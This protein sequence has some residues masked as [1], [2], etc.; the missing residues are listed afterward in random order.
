MS[1][2]SHDTGE[3]NVIFV[4]SSVDDYPLTPFEF[5]VYGKIARRA[6]QGEGWPSIEQV[7]KECLMSEDTARQ[8]LQN[9][10]TFGMLTRREVPGKR[11]RYRLTRPSTWAT[12]EVVAA[13]HA[14]QADKGRT[15]RQERKAKKEQAQNEPAP[16]TETAKSGPST[17]P[18]I[19]HP[20]EKQGGVES[21]TPGKNREG[22]PS[23]KHPPHPSEKQG[24]VSIS[25]EVDPVEV[26]PETEIGRE[27]LPQ[28]AVSAEGQDQDTGTGAAD[29]AGANTPTSP[30]VQE[31]LN[32][33]ANGRAPNATS[34]KD[35]PGAARPV[36][37]PVD[38]FPEGPSRKFLTGCF[39][40]E[41]L[42]R[43]LEEDPSR[44]DWF[45]LEAETFQ[46][47]KDDAVTTSERGKWKGTLIGLLDAETAKA[48]RA[49]RPRAPGAA[50]ATSITDQINARIA[51]TRRPE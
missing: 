32:P 18:N 51:A 36:E 38:N 15:K 6:G 13:L 44:A 40:G 22:Y 9:L 19:S 12:R 39:G 42:G 35:G 46:V 1:E 50:P 11:A 7:A 10:V 47:S 25:T 30:P 49:R 23:E 34:P 17:P 4:H 41:W 2:V 3:M 26:D 14:E 45:G 37:N 28:S 31:P 33:K 27:A 16:E 21:P 20:S 43:L 8:A 48:R 5:R 24:G 29:A